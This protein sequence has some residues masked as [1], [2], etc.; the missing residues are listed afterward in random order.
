MSIIDYAILA[1][2]KK[3][4]NGG[5]GGGGGGGEVSAII[6]PL[7]IT[8][9]GTYTAVAGGELKHDTTVKFKQTITADDF[10][11]YIA[12]ATISQSA[13]GTNIYTL[14]DD[15]ML[16]SP[17]AS[18]SPMYIIQNPLNPLL[19]LYTFGMSAMGMADGWKLSDQTIVDDPPM[20]SIPEGA[21]MSADLE[22]TAVFF[23][24]ERIDA[25]A[26][27]TVKSKE[28]SAMIAMNDAYVK[29]ETLYDDFVTDTRSYAFASCCT[30]RSIE[31]PNVTSLGS[32]SFKMCNAETV[33][34]PKATNIATETFANI[35][36]KKLDLSSCTEFH[37]SNLYGNSLK[38][39]KLNSITKIT[40]TT[41][42]CADLTALIL[43]GETVCEIP[44]GVFNYCYHI[45]GEAVYGYNSDGLKD[46][47]IY[48]PKALVETYKTATNWSAYA[49]QIRAIEDYPE[50]CEF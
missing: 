47:Y 1:E 2:V 11:T 22:T 8:N 37:T 46:G 3:L 14:F 40:G 21:T 44:A 15:W 28:L 42:D 41:L 33:K 17:S 5:S 48:V 7:T 34:L 19:P 18:D 45:T 32:Y 13:S 4:G 49:S 29:N 24:L 10:A 36:I 23:N 31:L 43:G 16:M 39:L 6:K 35:F 25:Y 50:E 27:I 38:K 26:P 9:N 20:V 12:T 30:F